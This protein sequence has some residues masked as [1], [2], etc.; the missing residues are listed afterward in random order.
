MA[1]W[2]DVLAVLV[3]ERGNALKRYGL[4]LTGDANVAED[5]VQEAIVR[6]LSRPFAQT[7][8]AS[9]EAYVRRAMA[10]LVIDTARQRGR[11][12]TRWHLTAAP[13]AAADNTAES[14]LRLDT[15]TAL[16][17]L[18]ARQR[19]CIVLRYWEDLTVPQ[20]A[21]CLGCGQGTVKRYLSEAIGRLSELVPEPEEKKT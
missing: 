6:A 11:W 10:N 2:R 8:V 16:N 15:F 4:L 17:R 7:D 3:T 21:S 14:S 13:E 19:V 5:I 9:A 20:I 1:E 12:R 18:P